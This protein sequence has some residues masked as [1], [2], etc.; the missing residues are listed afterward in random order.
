M[1]QHTATAARDALARNLRR[2]RVA[3]RWSLA[4]LA[5]ATG[6]GK[7]TLSAIENARA[8]PTVETLAAL[9]GALEVDVSALLEGTPG[10]EVTLVRSGDA[11]RDSDGA[12]RL[13]RLGERGAIQRMV[14]EPSMAVEC[15]PR[16]PGTRAHVVVAR[17]TVI[18]G[19]AGR[20]VEL[21]RGDYLSFPADA[22]HDFSTARRG[23][24]L[25]LVVEG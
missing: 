14:L 7:A 10:D 16:A 2:L 17:G 8:N 20:P 21:S 4:D 13:A 3:R 23:A 6:T 19:P 18:A 24:E 22:P 5:S 9:A 15:R 11:A 1:A 25:V 12:E